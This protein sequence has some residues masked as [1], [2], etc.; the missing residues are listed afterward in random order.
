MALVDQVYND[1]LNERNIYLT[2][3][4]RFLFKEH[5]KELAEEM[6]DA[7]YYELLISCRLRLFRFL[8]D[9]GGGGS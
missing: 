1:I 5:C 2:D 6:P 9:E 8:A 4:Q 7:G 3:R